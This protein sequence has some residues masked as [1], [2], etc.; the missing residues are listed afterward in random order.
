[1]SDIAELA[2]KL[3]FWKKKKPEEIQKAQPQTEPPRMTKPGVTI[4]LSPKVADAQKR[5]EDKMSTLHGKDLDNYVAWQK[6][7]A[8]MAKPADPITAEAWKRYEKSPLASFPPEREEAEKPT[9]KQKKSKDKP[10]I[11]E[12]KGFQTASETVD[13]ETTWGIKLSP[14]PEEEVKARKKSKK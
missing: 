10:L 13:K 4:Y 12:G 5:I 14:E 11:E 7:N 2:Q 6:K 3:V 1:M 8:A 9:G